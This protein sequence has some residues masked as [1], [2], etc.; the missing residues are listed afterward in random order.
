M[1]R[2][3]NISILLVLV[4]LLA[5]GEYAYMLFGN[6]ALSIGV[7]YDGDSNQLLLIEQRMNKTLETFMKSMTEKH[8]GLK[9]DDLVVILEKLKVI[10]NHLH[11][12]SDKNDSNTVHELLSSMDKRIR[13]HEEDFIT[14]IDLV[15]MKERLSSVER[16]VQTNKGNVTNLSNK[17]SSVDQRTIHAHEDVDMKSLKEYISSVEKKVQSITDAHI[18]SLGHPYSREP[19]YG[20]NN[21]TF[22]VPWEVNMDDWW[23][24]HVDWSISKE[25]ETHQCFAQIVDSEKADFLRKLYDIQ[26]HGNCSSVYTKLMWNSGWG[27]DIRN[28]IDGLQEAIK[29]SRP[30]EVYA[31]RPWHYAHVGPDRSV[32]PSKDYRCYFLDLSHCEPSSQSYN[33][34]LLN[35]KIR[36]D[37]NPGSWLYEY[38]TRQ[39]TWLRQK[40]LRFSSRINI[41]T[42]CTVAH[43]RRGDIVLHKNRVRRYHK[44]DDY[45]ERMDKDTKNI[46]L[47]TD[48]DNAIGEALTKY[49]TYNW[50]FINR[51]R[52]KGAEGGFEKQIPSKNPRFEVIVL[53]SIFRLVKKCNKLIHTR[54]GFSLLLRREMGKEGNVKNVN[55]DLGSPAYSNEYA[56]TR[57]ISKPYPIQ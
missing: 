2:V 27:A 36:L 43:V 24:H 39:Q 15:E 42:P 31:S 23:T 57:N 50:M 46:F 18:A 14:N 56:L 40:V 32:C 52:Y 8:A 22:C 21:Q 49:P 19:F 3:S 20:L 29:A 51:P 34:N 25:N 10:E 44:I 35:P 4:I 37:K 53:L 5:A 26:F 13:A 33:G 1:A 38:V 45:V 16:L 30:M 17:M 47:L 48:D 28:V 54:S 55:I 12:P 11:T 6:D 41:T 9:K 7:A